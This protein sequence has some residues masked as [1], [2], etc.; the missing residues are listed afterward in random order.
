M[1]KTEYKVQFSNLLA[2]QTHITRHLRGSVIDW[3]WEVS[4]KLKVTDKSVIYQ[5]VCLMDM[6][7][8]A[9]K[10]DFQSRDLQLTAVTAFFI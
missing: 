3:L 8:E 9:Q 5:A 10:K 2:H 1:R 7:Y 4:R 6:F